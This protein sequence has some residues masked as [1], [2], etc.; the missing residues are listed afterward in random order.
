MAPARGR[1]LWHELMCNDP[2]A[3]IGFYTKVIGWKR[4]PMENVPNYHLLTWK[5]SPMA[6]VLRV[7][8]DSKAMGAVPAWLPYLGCE[9][10]HVTAWEAQRLGGKVLKEPSVT[11]TVG[12]WAI[13]QDPQGAQ[14]AIIQPEV[15]PGPEQKPGLGDFSWHELATTDHK[16]AFK[17]YRELFGWRRTRSSDMGPPLGEYLMYGQG[18]FEYGG[19]YSKAPDQPGPAWVSYVNVANARKTTGLISGAGGM[20]MVGPMDVPGGDLITVAAD[21]QG[22]V[23][24]IHQRR[25]VAKSSVAKKGKPAKKKAAR[26]VT[27]RTAKPAK[28]AKPSARRKPAKKSKKRR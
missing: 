3:A 6:G 7:K 17:F 19:M 22:A 27:K 12:T 20:V 4:Q 16:A 13:L 1:F 24:A 2:S 25:A 18:R 11:P 15:K 23:F 28:R 10:A 26:K 14:F 9:D 5:D 8:G 21:P